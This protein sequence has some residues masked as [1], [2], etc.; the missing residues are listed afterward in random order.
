MAK[1]QF[2]FSPT[3][4]KDTLEYADQ[5]KQQET[6]C[7]KALNYGTSLDIASTI[8]TLEM[9]ITDKMIPKDDRFKS[10][11]F[12]LNAELEIVNT[13]SNEYYQKLLDEAVC[14]DLVTPPSKTAPKWYY[15]KKFRIL[16]GFFDRLGLGLQH[17]KEGHF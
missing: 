9:L 12:N 13:Q 1:F 8:N 7:R 10:E 17:E 16:I 11:I 5:I 15:Y 6:E 2:P 3:Y 4:F 14:P